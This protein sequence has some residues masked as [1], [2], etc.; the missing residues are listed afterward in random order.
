MSKYQFSA[1]EVHPAKPKTLLESS[2]ANLVP[3]FIRLPA[4]QAFPKWEAKISVASCWR[5]PSVGKKMKLVSCGLL[6]DVCSDFSKTGSVA[7]G[8]RLLQKA[9]VSTSAFL[10]LFCFAFARPKSALTFAGSQVVAEG[11]CFHK[12]LLKQF[13]KWRWTDLNRRHLP[14]KGSALPTELHPLK[15]Y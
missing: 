14:C 7:A 3:R 2:R 15:S 4:C 12:C 1:A 6:R 8:R 9:S 10:K 13:C 5:Q 11:K